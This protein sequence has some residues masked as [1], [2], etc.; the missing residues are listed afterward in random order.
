MNGLLPSEKNIITFLAS[1]LS[2][3][4]FV[5]RRGMDPVFH[6]PVQVRN[7]LSAIFMDRY[8]PWLAT[9]VTELAK[10]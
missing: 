2:L 5:K 8:D 4:L 3:G 10:H 6:S 9:F 1:V 7:F